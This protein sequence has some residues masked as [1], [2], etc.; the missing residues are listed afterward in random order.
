MPASNECLL[1]CDNWNEVSWLSA[2]REEMIF[3][4]SVPWRIRELQSKP[5]PTW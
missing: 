4:G 2:P 5:D 3:G 1:V